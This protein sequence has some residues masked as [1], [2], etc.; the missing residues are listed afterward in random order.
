[1]ALLKDINNDFVFLDRKKER[2]EGFINSII[3]LNRNNRYSTKFEKDAIDIKLL[4]STL[5][6]GLT[7][8]VRDITIQSK[9]VVYNEPN[10][11]LILYYLKKYVK[12]GYLTVLIEHKPRV[13]TITELGKQILSQNI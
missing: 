10:N 7:L 13:Y 1:M 9:C 5:L 8:S 6:Q 4:N 11:Y 2:W 12:L 3:D